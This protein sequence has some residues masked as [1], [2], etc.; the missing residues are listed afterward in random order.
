MADSFTS[1]NRSLNWALLKRKTFYKPSVNLEQQLRSTQ[2]P[3][4]IHFYV[5]QIETVYVLAFNALSS[6]VAFAFT[7]VH[8]STSSCCAKHTRVSSANVKIPH[9]NAG[10][11]LTGC[12]M[13]H[14]ASTHSRCRRACSYCAPWALFANSKTKRRNLLENVMIGLCGGQWR[15]C[16]KRDLSFALFVYISFVYFIAEIFPRDFS[17]FKMKPEPTPTHACSMA[18]VKPCGHPRKER[19]LDTRYRSQTW[20]AISSW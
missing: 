19:G 6:G 16:E 13:L 15:Q 12:T 2:A 10:F 20:S 4:P 18:T 5:W 17:G 8:I 3:W 11:T 9:L 7:F 1:E 14:A